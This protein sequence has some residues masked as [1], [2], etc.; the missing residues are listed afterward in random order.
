VW[1]AAAHTPGQCSAPPAGISAYWY[2]TNNRG[3]WA[4]YYPKGPVVVALL[5]CT[6]CQPSV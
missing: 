6:P 3:G 2:W 4:K 1:V 5:A